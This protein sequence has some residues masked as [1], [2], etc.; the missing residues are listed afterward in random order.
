MTSTLQRGNSS[1][2]KACRSSKVRNRRTATLESAGVTAV[3]PS[4]R[5]T[6]Q[7]SSAARSASAT[8]SFPDERLPI[9]RTASIGSCVGPAVMSSRLGRSWSR[10]VPSVGMADRWAGLARSLLLG[11]WE[12]SDTGVMVSRMDGLSVG[13]VAGV[14]LGCTSVSGEAGSGFPLPCDGHRP[15]A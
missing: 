11:G 3:G 7:P 8:P 2:N 9:N 10:T 6:C 12:G 5:Q 14:L 4:N 15:E 1:S 13:C